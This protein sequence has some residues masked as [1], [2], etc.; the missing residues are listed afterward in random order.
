MLYV[1]ATMRVFISHACEDKEAVARPLALGLRSRGVDVW[2][3]EFSISLGDSLSACI[4][5]GLLSCDVGIIIVSPSF[6]KKQWTQRELSGLMAREVGE[7]R[8]LILPV[9]HGV[10][11]AEVRAFSP[12][13]ADRKAAS[14]ADG[15]ASVIAQV[16][17]AVR[18]QRTGDNVAAR[19][20]NMSSAEGWGLYSWVTGALLLLVGLFA[21]FEREPVSRREE[22]PKKLEVATSH[23]TDAITAAAPLP[24]NELAESVGCVE[25]LP[26]GDFSPM[27]SALFED[28]SLSL[29]AGRYVKPYYPNAPN[30]GRLRTH[31]K[32]DSSFWAEWD[33]DDAGRIVFVKDYRGRGYRLFYGSGGRLRNLVDS[34]KNRLDFSYDEVGRL[35]KIKIPDSTI[36]HEVTLL[37]D[38]TGSLGGLKGVNGSIRVLS[39]LAMLPAM[40]VTVSPASR[41]LE[42]WD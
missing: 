16:T 2:F 19:S 29:R 21:L 27:P 8:K 4:D 18:F 38:A 35:E 32:F 28:F 26:H 11:E 13:L 25:R 40:C 31:R 12:M 41:Y 33:V 30:A 9:W 39:A 24:I 14:T 22:E 6:I 15:V 20:P 36:W 3:D 1:L 17:A 37:R 34:Q 10:S 42:T 7:A 5:R 23:G